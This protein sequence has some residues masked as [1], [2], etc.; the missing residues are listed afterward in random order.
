MQKIKQVGQGKVRN[1]FDLGDGRLVLYTTDR[2]SAF[3]MVLPSQIPQKG[4]VLNAI[5]A[6]WFNF[7]RDIIPNHMISICDTD[8]PEEFWKDEFLGHC[9]L[10]KKKE[11]IAKRDGAVLLFR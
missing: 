7:T 2:F 8:M 11:R 9:M 5:S 6:F 3:D 4:A 10:V 1:I